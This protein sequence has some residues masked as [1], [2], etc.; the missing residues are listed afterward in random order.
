MQDKY[1]KDILTFFDHPP[2]RVVSLVPSLTESLFDL[3]LGRAV[4][5]ISDYCIHPA[6]VLEGIPRVGGPKTPRLEDILALHP[7]LVLMDRDENTPEGFASLEASGVKTWVTFTKTA[8]QALDLLWTLAELFQSQTAVLRLESLEKALDWANMAVNET[9]RRVRYFCP[10]WKGETSDGNSWWMTFNQ[11]TYMSDLLAVFGGENVFG[12]RERQYP[13]L[14]ELGFEAAED[15]LDRDR[16]FPRV[17]FE[18]IRASDPELILLPD[19]PFP[20]DQ[21]HKDI[22]CKHLREVRAVRIGRVY[23]V[24]GSLITWHGTRLALALQFL[25]KLFI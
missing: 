24:D 6:Q 13:L 25:P 22:I 3:G 20:F 11:D 9:D 21:T 23:L 7:E 18:E 2:S 15:P 12:N 10:I 1:L 19:E 4:V 17:T 8:R 14:A 5:G 16:R